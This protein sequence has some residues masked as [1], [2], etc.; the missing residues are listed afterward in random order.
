M[1][2]IKCI[3]ENA[4]ASVWLRHHAH[5]VEDLVEDLGEATELTRHLLAGHERDGIPIWNLQARTG[6]LE[7][8]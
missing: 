2:S 3:R 5:D 7:Q 6:Y 8:L 1:C 4:E